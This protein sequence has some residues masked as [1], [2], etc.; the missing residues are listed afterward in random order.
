MSDAPT[1][2]RPSLLSLRLSAPVPIEPIEPEPHE[3]R[4]KLAKSRE[5]TK[6]KGWRLHRLLGVGPVTAAYEAFF[7]EDGPAESKDHAVLKLLVGGVAKNERARGLFLRSVYAAN[8]FRHQRVV[9]ITLDGVDEDGTPFVVRP[10]HDAEPLD[11]VVA[12]EA[13]NEAKVLRIAEQV[14]D[15]L[16]LAHSHGIVHG[17]ITPSNILVNER[18]SMRLCDFATPP[19]AT[20]TAG[21]ASAPEGER[22]LLGM[23]RLGPFT[24]PERCETPPVAGA[25]PSD[26]YALAACMYFALTKKYPRGDATTRDELATAAVIPVRDALPSGVTVTDGF[27]AIMEHALR[28]EPA[29]RYESAYAMLG[30]VRRTMAGRRPKLDAAL[31]PVPSG[32]YAQLPA[33]AEGS[34]RAV[35]ALVPEIGAAS[36]NTRVE[37]RKKEWRGNV[38]LILAIALLVGIATFVLVREKREDASDPPPPPAAQPPSFH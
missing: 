26:I 28:R 4:T 10:W 9:G 32:S 19:G 37:R 36:I 24:A 23:L 2:D 27:A 11:A 20:A 15:A 21:A 14:L 31:R 22:D 17:A 6:A 5:G 34:S 38:L 18:G 16:E 3:E 1:T 33:T 25:E 8:R 35:P 12:R 13:F 29:R 7:G 30:D